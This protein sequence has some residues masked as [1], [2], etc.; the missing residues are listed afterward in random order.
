MKQKIKYKQNPPTIN[1]EQVNNSPA[2]QISLYLW[3]EDTQT[4]NLNT[5][6]NTGIFHPH[7][8]P[9]PYLET[10]DTPYDL[11]AKPVDVQIL[12]DDELIGLFVLVFFC[13]G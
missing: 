6:S 8:T 13:F 12:N 10:P 1:Y 3:N 5:D 4:L 9:C 11:L 7:H 2:Y